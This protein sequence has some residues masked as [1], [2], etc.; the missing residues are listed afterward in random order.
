M[1]LLQRGLGLAAGEFFVGGELVEHRQGVGVELGPGR[2]HV[3]SDRPEPRSARCLAVFFVRP[4]RPV[5][6]RI[7]MFEMGLKFETPL[8]PAR[9][10]GGG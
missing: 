7:T 5:R 10:D 1:Q 9:G 3:R 6:G 8:S 4:L 2:V